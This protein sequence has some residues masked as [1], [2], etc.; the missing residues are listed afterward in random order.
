[1]PSLPP[2]L[3]QAPRS[4]CVVAV[5]HCPAWLG[6]ILVQASVGRV[7]SDTIEP[8]PPAYWSL[9][10]VQLGWLLYCVEYEL[11]GSLFDCQAKLGMK[12]DEYVF[13]FVGLLAVGSFTFEGLVQIEWGGWKVL[14]VFFHSNC[15]V[16][17]EVVYISHASKD[18]T[19]NKYHPGESCSCWIAC[20][21]HSICLTSFMLVSWLFHLCGFVM[22][23]V[24]L[25]EPTAIT[26]II[27]YQFMASLGAS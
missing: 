23:I 7:Y 2:L 17:D 16:L 25:S 19:L 9:Q 4:A 26:S 20:R 12:G 21:S 5:A 27:S 13:H 22:N 15:K 18:S 14:V 1:M 11:R 3:F 6:R 8:R 10:R 24:D